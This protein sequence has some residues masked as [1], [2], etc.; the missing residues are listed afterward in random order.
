MTKRLWR[1][2]NLDQVANRWQ[3]WLKLKVPKNLS[4][5][6]HQTRE[7]N[8]QKPMIQG[9]MIPDQLV[10]SPFTENTIRH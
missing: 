5:R 6:N 3:I 4:D 8:H 2:S 9:L 10:Q 7:L 1:S